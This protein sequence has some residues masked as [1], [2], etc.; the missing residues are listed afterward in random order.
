MPHYTQLST[1]I[2]ILAEFTFL[3]SGANFISRIFHFPESLNR[4]FCSGYSLVLK[5]QEYVSSGW[6]SNETSVRIK[7]VRIKNDVLE[8]RK[9]PVWSGEQF[10]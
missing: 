4:D 9:T 3:F 2:I 8:L 1:S 6:N 10:R 5:C 7:F